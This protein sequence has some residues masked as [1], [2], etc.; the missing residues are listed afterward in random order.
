L[1]S[2]NTTSFVL[3][4]L[5][6]VSALKLAFHRAAQRAGERGRPDRGGRW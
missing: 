3:M 5:S 2:A 6:T 1:A 4:S